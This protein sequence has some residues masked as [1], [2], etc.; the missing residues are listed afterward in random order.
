MEKKK[1]EIKVSV[2]T[3]TYNRAKEVKTLYQSLCN[4]TDQ[5]FVWWIIDDGSD[6]ETPVLLEDWSEANQ[7]FCLKKAIRRHGGKHRALNWVAGHLTGD[8]VIV[9]DS[10]DWLMPNAIATIKEQWERFGCNPRVQSMVFE[11]GKTAHRALNPISD[12]PFVSQRFHYTSRN[13]MYGDFSDVFTVYAFQ[14]CLLPEFENEDFLTEG[15]MYLAFSK[16]YLSAFIPEILIVGEY[17]SKGLSNRMRKLQLANPQGTLAE[18]VAYLVE[19]VPLLFKLKKSLLVGI[20]CHHTMGWQQVRKG[21]RW[22]IIM[23]IPSLF[24]YAYLR[25]RGRV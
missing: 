20:V 18:N 4:Q 8:L 13:K 7:T 19:P 22:V 1:E 5:D 12:Q 23:A 24:A 17:R 15:L 2:V 21:R 11:R 9:V 3:P 6:D 14:T 16:R 10:D 25:I